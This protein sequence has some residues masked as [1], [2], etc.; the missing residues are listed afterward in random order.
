MRRTITAIVIIIGIAAISLADETV[1]VLQRG[2]TI[3]TLTRMY[4]VSAE[5]LLR[6]NGIDDP[7]TLPVGARIRIPGTYTV[8][9][10]E[11]IYSIATKLGVNWLELLDM[12]DLGRND[13]VR[14]GDVLLVPRDGVGDVSE[15]SGTRVTEGPPNTPEPVNVGRVVDS[16]EPGVPVAEVEWPHPGE[17]EQWDGS[18]PGVVIAGSPGDEFRSVSSGVVSFVAS[19]TS[20]GILTFVRSENGYVYGYAGAGEVSVV[21][22]QRVENGTVIGTVGVSPAFQSA[23]VLLTVWRNNRY[24]DPAQAPRG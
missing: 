17:R 8:Q 16:P 7:T 2:Q 24:V 22:G 12:N 4:G 11:Y 13:V 10:G 5:E 9:D 3:Y 14:P 15:S 21:Q 23:R 1:H 18:F 6:Y 20:F 19:Y